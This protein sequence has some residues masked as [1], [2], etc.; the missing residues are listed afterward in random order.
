MQC[1]GATSDSVPPSYHRPQ[2]RPKCFGPVH[3]RDDCL[4]ACFLLSQRESK[5]VGRPFQECEL[6]TPPLLRTS[7]ATLGDSSNVRFMPSA[8]VLARA[9]KPTC[10]CRS[11][12]Q[13]CLPRKRYLNRLAPKNSVL[14]V[15][16]A[17]PAFGHRERRALK[18]PV[19]PQAQAVRAIAHARLRSK[20]PACWVLRKCR[21]RAVAQARGGLFRFALRFLTISFSRRSSGLSGPAQPA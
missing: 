8:S 5:H 14:G 6:P 17:R 9:V 10:P 15:G 20:A 16:P 1:P 13:R 7:P 19:P 11:R 3:G 18:E 2:C 4:G 12:G 21:Q